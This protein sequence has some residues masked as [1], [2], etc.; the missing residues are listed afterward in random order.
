[1]TKPDRPESMLLLGEYGVGKTNYGAQLLK[2]LMKGDGR[3]SMEPGAATNLKPFE[4]A[5]RSL[6]EGIAPDHTPA[7]IYVESV[8]PIHDSIGH[9]VDLVWPDY[10]GEQVGRVI[11]NRHLPRPWHERVVSSSAWIL[12]LRL[13]LIRASEDL[14]SKPI[15]R[16][17]GLETDPGEVHPSDASRLVEFLQMLLFAQHADTH[18]PLRSPRLMVL[19]SCWDELGTT[20]APAD[21]LQTRIPLF[22]DFVHTQWEQPLILGLSATERPLSRDH[23]DPEYAARGPEQFGYA[24]LAD[25]QRTPDLTVPIHLLFDQIGTT[26]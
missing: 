23:R 14:F 12:M 8:W 17:Q 19:L 7:S 1:M 18:S 9:H 10:G 20:S 13:Q 2:R 26:G 11:Q 24:I 25:G 15:S 22:S 21:V 6:D 16:L 4:D 5:M 3:L